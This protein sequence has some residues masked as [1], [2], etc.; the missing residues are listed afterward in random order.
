VSSSLQK[1]AVGLVVMATMALLLTTAAIAAT[2]S[3]GA[4]APG[5]DATM[6]PVI[7]SGDSRSDGEGPGFVGSPVAI[8]LGVVVLGVITAVG[9]LVVLRATGPRRGR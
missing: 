1:A 8:A 9:T 5:P 7:G 2:P 3:P 4:S 6:P